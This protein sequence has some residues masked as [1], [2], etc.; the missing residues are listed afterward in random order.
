MKNIIILFSL[1]LLCSCGQEE[2]SSENTDT[3]DITFVDDGVVYPASILQKTRANYGDSLDWVN[4]DKVTLPNG[5]EVDLPWVDGGSL[6]FFMQQKLS[7]NNGWELVAHTMRPET[8]NNR[9]YLVFHNYITGVLRVFC[10]MTTYA[11]NNNGYWKISFSQPTSLLN[12]T[13]KYAL[14]MDENGPS[15]IVVSNSTTQD[16]KGFAL[17]WNGF[18]LELAYDPDAT[19]IMQIIPM[20]VTATNIE[21]NGALEAKTE[22]TI[23][24]NEMSSTPASNVVKGIGKL[25]GESAEQWLKAKLPFI[26]I[27]DSIDL[28]S[29]ILGLAKSGVTS[30]FTGFSGLFEKNTQKILNVNMTTHGDIKMTGAATTPTAAPIIPVNL[31]L[32]MMGCKL[33][34]WNLAESPEMIWWSTAFNQVDENV[35]VTNRE[36]I[37]QVPQPESLSFDIVSNPKAYVRKI[38]INTCF[39]RSHELPSYVNQGS[40]EY[41]PGIIS[42]DEPDFEYNGSVVQNQAFMRV[43]ASLPYCET[44]ADIPQLISF[45]D[46]NIKNYI[47]EYWRTGNYI[48][49][50]LQFVYK[51]TKVINGVENEYVS[52]RTVQCKRHTW[53][54]EY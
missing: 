25:A 17:G 1:F 43:H 48:D 26:K 36:Y 24:S 44:S 21:L 47:V 53:G 22:G 18:E 30:I 51:G 10:Y 52:S 13:G 20:N 8:Q 49:F 32:D 34:G 7:P 39:V 9:A 14:P 40:L 41:A 28:T 4:S 12:F 15:E 11:V 16:G 2:F 35:N 46:P 31:N 45:T 23:I 54:S 19:G 6:P 33:G 3:K 37:Y 29:S 27:G 50:Y 5:E 38:D 42:L